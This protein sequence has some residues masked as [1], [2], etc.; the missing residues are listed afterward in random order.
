MRFIWRKC[1]AIALL[2]CC[3]LP[4]LAVAQAPPAR[5]R[6]ATCT[7]S[8]EGHPYCNKTPIA[9][10]DVDSALRA[11]LDSLVGHDLYTCARY[12]E[13]VAEF[14]GKLY[15]AVQE[16]GRVALPVVVQAFEPLSIYRVYS[17]NIPG[18]SG[19]GFHIVVRLKSD[20]LGVVRSDAYPAELRNNQDP[21]FS[22]LRNMREPVYSDLAKTP[23]TQGEIDAIDQHHVEVG[24]AEAVAQCILGS[25]IRK[26]SDSQKRAVNLYEDGSRV[27]VDNGYV[28]AITRKQ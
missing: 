19:H 10:L 3:G 11:Q 28:V 18:V 2:L 27:T 20:L 17:S 4:I 13:Q 16:G 9:S 24:T 1:N 6:S 22:L 21:M 7:Y 14:E 23:F 15:G 5:R 26:G 12:I 25:P 8:P